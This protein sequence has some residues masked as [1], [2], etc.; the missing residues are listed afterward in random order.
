ME[1]P[2]PFYLH[3][4]LRLSFGL[5]LMIGLSG[6]AEPVY[7]VQALPGETHLAPALGGLAQVGIRHTGD[8][9][10]FEQLDFEPVQDRLYVGGVG[11]YYRITAPV[12]QMDPESGVVERTYSVAALPRYAA[13]G[14]GGHYYFF[15]NTYQDAGDTRVLRL[16]LDTGATDFEFTTTTE[17][18]SAV[19]G[20]WPVS[21]LSDSV[22]VATKISA[23]GMVF[24]VF[25]HGV[26]RPAQATIPLTTQEFGL[27][28]GNLLYGRIY[29]DWLFTSSDLV[30][31]TVENDGVHLV[32]RITLPSSL[33]ITPLRILD[34]LVYGAN[35]VVFD[36]ETQT[37][38]RTYALP[39]AGAALLADPVLHRIQ[40][41]IPT[42][43]GVDV[44]VANG[45]EVFG[46]AH[47][48]DMPLADTY[49]PAWSGPTRFC[50]KGI[51]YAGQHLYTLT[52]L[53]ASAWL[54]SLL[55]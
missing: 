23:Q 27:A 32:N 19:A 7:M 14:V 51:P 42:A 40:I 15:D 47:L 50:L 8:L 11:D 30:R 16:N 31:L 1:T 9:D 33:R 17:P 20:L 37:V 49:L 55:K 18:S 25:D 26:A 43:T 54:P 24:A 3:H 13:V 10:S 12:Y 29:S 6:L 53:S 41:F 44:F 34:G 5:S 52:T 39:G 28:D 36:P 38:I 4:S 45:T 48:P 21:G 35:G 22:A 2:R 46:T